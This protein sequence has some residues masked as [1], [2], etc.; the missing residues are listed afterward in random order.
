MERQREKRPRLLLPRS[1]RGRRTKWTQRDFRFATKRPPPPR[2]PDVWESGVVLFSSLSL[3]KS[4]KGCSP[5]ALP[6]SS[7][8]LFRNRM[9]LQ[10]S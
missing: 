5:S 6:D 4:H 7:K 3:S 1:R 2:S 9:D 10:R 8:A